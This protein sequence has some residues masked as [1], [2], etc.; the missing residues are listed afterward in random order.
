MSSLAQAAEAEIK[1]LHA[2]FVGLFMGDHRDLAR[3]AAALADDMQMVSPDGTRHD[4]SQI[5]AGIGAATA[6][7]GFTI[8]IHGIRP[9]WE[10]GTAVLLQYVEEQYRDGETTRRLSSALFT[11]DAAAPCGVV[12]RYLHE[13]WLP[14]PESQET[15]E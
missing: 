9:I 7:P 8:R 10:Q 1:S 2:Y 15:N 13:T 6:A 3:C 5:L 11:A 4:R 12:W 14:P